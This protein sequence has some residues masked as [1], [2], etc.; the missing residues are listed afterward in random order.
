M[1]TAEANKRKFR[2]EDILDRYC[3]GFKQ[4]LLE[5]FKVGGE[6]LGF[7][8][9]VGSLDYNQPR[10]LLNEFNDEKDAKKFFDEQVSKLQQ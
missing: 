5:I 3:R 6:V 7:Y 8:V 1:D 4:V 2:Q 10:D 9:S